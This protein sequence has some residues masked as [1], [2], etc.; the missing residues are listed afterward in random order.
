MH[1]SICGAGVEKS[2][3]TLLVPAFVI[4]VLGTACMCFNNG[5]CKG[6]KCLEI[7]LRSVVIGGGPPPKSKDVHES[8]LVPVTE[9]NAIDGFVRISEASSNKCEPD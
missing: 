1:S 9:S 6:A 7:D 5:I 4:L 3:F 2:V 8:E